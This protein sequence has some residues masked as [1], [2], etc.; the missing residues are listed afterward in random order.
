VQ[1]RERL[2]RA[3]PPRD[4][5]LSEVGVQP[6][7]ALDQARAAVVLARQRDGAAGHQ[8]PA[9][10]LQ[11]DAGA[12]QLGRGTGPA[13]R[14]LRRHLRRAASKDAVRQQAVDGGA[15]LGHRRLHTGQGSQRGEQVGHARRR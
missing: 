6:D 3:V 11:L 1:P 8:L 4:E 7:G 12:L 13:Q 10:A 5:Q 2:P 14:R 15:G 9:Q